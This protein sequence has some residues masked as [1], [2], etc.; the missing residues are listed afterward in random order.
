MKKRPCGRFFYALNP[1]L[2]CLF[3]EMCLLLQILQN[4]TLSTL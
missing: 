3:C 1:L 2:G 4:F